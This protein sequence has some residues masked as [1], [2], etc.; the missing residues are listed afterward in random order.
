MKMDGCWGVWLPGLFGL[1]QGARVRI[2]RPGEGAIES[3]QVGRLWAVTN[4][5][6]HPHPSIQFTFSTCM[7]VRCHS[8][9]TSAIMTD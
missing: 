3:S 2:R 6:T 8:D 7:A 5:R 1:W 4:A 9:D